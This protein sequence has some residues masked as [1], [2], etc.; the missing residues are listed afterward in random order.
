MGEIRL[1]FQC[2]DEIFQFL[3]TC[4]FKK[5]ECV[6]KAWVKVYTLAS[7]T[8]DV[9]NN[10][11]NSKEAITLKGTSD[12][13]IDTK[14]KDSGK[15]TKNFT[16]VK[17]VSKSVDFNDQK[18]SLKEDFLIKFKTVASEVL[19]APNGEAHWILK[20]ICQLESIIKFY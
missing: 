20:H 8:K 13:R 5:N 16:R 19:R 11:Q 15:E 12:Y 2:C 17:K 7:I 6:L 14:E 4:K 18:W 9:W 10:V 1:C 3:E